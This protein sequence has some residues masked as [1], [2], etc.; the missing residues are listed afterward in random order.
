MFRNVEIVTSWP[1]PTESKGASRQ[2]SSGPEGLSGS[3]PFP[4]STLCLAQILKVTWPLLA[5]EEMSNVAVKQGGEPWGALPHEVGAHVHTGY[6][7][8][9]LGGLLVKMTWPVQS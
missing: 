5:G 9:P 2:N 3:T 8:V 4:I 7:W 1:K 6:R